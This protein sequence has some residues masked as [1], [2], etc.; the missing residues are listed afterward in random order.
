MRLKKDESVVTAYAQPANGP[1]WANR[2]VWVVVRKNGT[3]DYRLECIQ[4][5]EHSVE[6]QCLYS[7]AAL[8]QGQMTKA[9]ER[10]L[11]NTR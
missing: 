1:G 5:D 11:R 10:L 6:M 9:A 8:V 7:I 3:D 4:P 2:P